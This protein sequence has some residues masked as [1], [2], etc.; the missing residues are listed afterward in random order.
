[1]EIR[2]SLKEDQG[3]CA[4]ATGDDAAMRMDQLG[5]EGPIRSETQGRSILCDRE[6]RSFYRSFLETGRGNF[7]LE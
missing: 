5:R 6:K 2:I 4:D 3:L 7:G 1:M